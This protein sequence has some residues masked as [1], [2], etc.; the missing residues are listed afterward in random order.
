MGFSNIKKI[1]L[2]LIVLSFL[3]PAGIA[4][5]QVSGDA[6]SSNTGSLLAETNPQYP[7]PNSDVTVSLISYQIDLNR[8][9]ITWTINDKLFKSGR[10]E[11]VMV[12]KTGN[13]GETVRIFVTAETGAGEILEKELS[14]TPLG[15]DLLW[16]AETYTPP[17]YK[18][19][20]V[21]TNQAEIKVIALPIFFDTDG[22]KIA[23]SDL[24]YKWTIDR[25]VSRDFSG[26]GKN[27]IKIPPKTIAPQTTIEVQVTDFEGTLSMKKGVIL[28]PVQPKVLVY[29]N[30]PL[31][32]I[33]NQRAIKGNLS[34]LSAEITLS[35]IP[36][37]FS[38]KNRDDGTIR[39]RWS[40]NGKILP[41]L[42]NRSDATFR[43]EDGVS[44][45][46]SVSITAENPTAFLQSGR[47]DLFIQYNI[48]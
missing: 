11:K 27:I 25:Q 13:F 23:P 46:S 43:P 29:E 10:G 14:I 7:G 17:F 33:L 19:K 4:R 38:T 1:A 31:Y 22:N 30:N 28:D 32:G 16:E 3:L 37:F 24:I 9:D 44:G 6:S 12:I 42:N 5:A 20:A 26:Y 36:Y 8:A 15:I 34:L 39:Y 18:G 41:A 48:N 35:A 2:P 47:A 40:L 45:K 21:Y